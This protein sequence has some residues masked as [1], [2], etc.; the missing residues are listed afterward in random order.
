MKSD[1]FERKK[2]STTFLLVRSK[3]IFLFFEIF[4]DM[5]DSHIGSSTSQQ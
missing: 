5:D 2:I 1:Y 4:S 3:R